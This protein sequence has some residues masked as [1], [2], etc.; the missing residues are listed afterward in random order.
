[1]H[2]RLYEQSSQLEA[3]REALRAQQTAAAS[4]ELTFKPKLTRRALELKHAD[5]ALGR[6]PHE[7]LYAKAEELAARKHDLV[8]EAMRAL[9]FKP[10]IDPRSEAILR[11]KPRGGDVVARLYNP[12]AVMRK[13]DPERK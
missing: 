11:G 10:T 8:V 2:D 13:S 7:M 4:E 1:V 9:P 6:S 12:D 5:A 3:R